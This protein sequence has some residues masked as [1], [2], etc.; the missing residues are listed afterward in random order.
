MS[1]GDTAR[2]NARTGPRPSER[3][4]SS[5]AGSTRLSAPATGSTTYGRHDADSTSHAAAAPSKPG[6]AATQADAVTYDGIASGSAAATSHHRPPGTSVRVITQ[7]SGMPTATQVAA[8]AAA[9]PT[10]RS[11]SASV[12][13]CT[14]VS[15][16][17]SQ[18]IPLARTTR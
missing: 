10:L 16:A 17:A 3:A 15:S 11:D 1:S 12:R 5:S 8:T 14:S 4:T 9:S 7:A 6:N 18:P 13:C 2:W